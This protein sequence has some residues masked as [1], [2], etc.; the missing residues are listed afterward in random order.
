M[1][2]VFHPLA[3]S[4]RALPAPVTVGGC[5]GWSTPQRSTASGLGDRV[6][7]R[8][9][10]RNK[11]ENLWKLVERI[12]LHLRRFF[13]MLREIAEP[14]ITRGHP[15]GGRTRQVIVFP[16][17]MSS[18]GEEAFAP[19]AMERCHSDLDGD[20]APVTIERSHSFVGGDRT[21]LTSQVGSSSESQ[22]NSERAL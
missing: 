1:R 18:S 21:D 10:G 14:T 6:A 5:A 16:G 3:A 9:R 2:S 7:E 22:G 4:C 11:L 20:R 12:S 17:G 19:L 15:K 13:C 8:D